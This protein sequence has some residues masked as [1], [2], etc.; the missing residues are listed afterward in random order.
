MEQTINQ[1]FINHRIVRNYEDYAEANFLQKMILNRLYIYHRMIKLDLYL[2]TFNTQA[3]NS[4]WI[5]GLSIEDGPLK[6]PEE[7]IS[8]AVNLVT[9]TVI[10]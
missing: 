7:T 3:Q 9:V 10:F 1:Q 8:E 2:I 6:L 4:K 5:E